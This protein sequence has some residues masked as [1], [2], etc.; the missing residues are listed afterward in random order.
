[1]DHA[2]LLM[3]VLVSLFASMVNATMTPTLGPT[4]AVEHRRHQ[5]AGVEAANP[6][7]R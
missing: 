2:T 4:L 6:R 7:E 1:M 5:V 3:I